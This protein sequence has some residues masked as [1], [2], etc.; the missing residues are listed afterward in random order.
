MATTLTLLA[1]TDGINPIGE[2]GEVR[3]FTFTDRNRSVGTWELSVPW[4]HPARPLLW[5]ASAG[6]I[7]ERVIDDAEATRTV[8]F[9]GPVRKRRRSFSAQTGELATF[10]GASDLVWLA[11]RVAHPQP[12]SATPPYSTTAYDTSSGALEAVVQHF[13]DVN[14]YAFALPA[15][16]NIAQVVGPLPSGPAAVAQARWT[17]LLDL[18]A[19]LAA[20]AGWG[21]Y[22]RQR[23]FGMR[24]PTDRAALG[25]EFS[26]DRGNLVDY[27]LVQAAPTA[28]Y[29]YVGGAGTG[30]ARTIVEGLDPASIAEWGR[31]ETFIDRRDTTNTTDLTGAAAATLT[32]QAGTVSATVTVVDIPTVRWGADYELG[33][34]VAARFDDVEII[35]VIEELTVTLGADGLTIKP[36][37]GSGDLAPG[38]LVGFAKRIRQISAQ[39]DQLN[40]VQ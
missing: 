20:R 16:Q 5:Q 29:V 19:G 40:T 4:D 23:G 38:S 35:D 21:I 30:T 6:I 13:I 26:T 11:R 37:I 31:I 14:A 24:A 1:T 10:Y 17:N 9:S 28:N 12:A 25:V 3:Y 36:T 39:V 27:D 32:E 33:D 18:V 22:V 34:I 15:R 2:L 8:V 7:V